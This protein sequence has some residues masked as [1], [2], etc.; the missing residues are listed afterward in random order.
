[1]DI[2]VALLAILLYA[3]ERGVAEC[4]NLCGTKDNCRS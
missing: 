2:Q 3:N 1:M 4:S